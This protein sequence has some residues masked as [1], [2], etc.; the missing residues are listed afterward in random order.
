MTKIDVELKVIFKYTNR[1]KK[2]VSY[3]QLYSFLDK[4]Y[5]HINEIIYENN[6]YT[7]EEYK[8]IYS[9]INN[10]NFN[11]LYNIISIERIK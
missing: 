3:L 2:M 4:E 11:F 10:D 9:K 7:K 5:D 8:K 6:T 1:D